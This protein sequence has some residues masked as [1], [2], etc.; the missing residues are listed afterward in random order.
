[1]FAR[2]AAFLLALLGILGGA[3]AEVELPISVETARVS[4]RA[5]AGLEG[6]AKRLAGRAE[7]DLR[8]IS[9]D[10]PGGIGES[11]G[12]IEVRLV[13]HA[14]SIG[15]AGYGAPE[16]AV[17]VAYPKM[18]VVVV[19]AR[20]RRGQ[21]IDMESTLA[22]ELAH[23][24]LE[25]A[26][27]DGRPTRWLTE[28]F[29][30]LH[31]SDFSLA[32]AQT[33]FGAV[34]AQKLVPLA[35]LEE[36]FPARE[37][38]A[39]LAYAQSYDFVAFLARRGRYADV[40]DDGDRAPFRAFLAG[41]AAGQSYDVAATEAFGRTLPQ[42]EDEWLARIRDRYLWMPVG[43]GSAFLWALAALL[44]V[45]GFARRR[46]QRNARMRQWEIEE[47]LAEAAERA[48]EAEGRAEQ[49]DGLPN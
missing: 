18:G 25:R 28:G 8:R 7:E 42:L 4:I 24:A 31:S 5:E 9:A 21:L 38:E 40:K 14:E 47:A 23:I 3:R 6:R 17:G 39:G 1:M 35:L 46:R 11:G 34:V 26:L 30:Y 2:A 13:K 41:I 10:L 15:E 48:R 36:R 32:R 45:L 12:K 19:A 27:G 43:M 20:D 29:A 49:R 37:D 44:V 16:W 22:H 33:L